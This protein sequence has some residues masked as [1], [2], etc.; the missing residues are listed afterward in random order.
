MLSILSKSTSTQIL[1][2]GENNLNWRRSYTTPLKIHMEPKNHRIEIRKIIDSKFQTSMTLGSKCYTI[3]Q[4]LSCVA[5]L[6]RACLQRI[7]LKW[8]GNV[9]FLPFSVQDV[10]KG[11]KRTC[12][13]CIDETLIWIG[14]PQSSVAVMLHWAG[15]FHRE[16]HVHRLKAD[17]MSDP[18]FNALK[19]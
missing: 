13:N 5:G 16:L 2:S 1:N 11:W 18:H 7:M 8:P 9:I 3:F 15:S 10:G 12:R 6:P 4:G 19:L 17:C 14:K